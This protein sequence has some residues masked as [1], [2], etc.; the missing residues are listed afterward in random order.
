[1]QFS[2]LPT[3]GV[4]VLAEDNDSRYQHHNGGDEY[5]WFLVK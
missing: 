5:G 4:H 3:L 2:L 1:M